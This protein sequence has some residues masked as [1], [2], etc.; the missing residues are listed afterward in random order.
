M[1]RL[2]FKS[3]KPPWKTAEMLLLKNTGGNTKWLKDWMAE[4]PDVQN[5]VTNPTS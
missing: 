2:R 4:N 5:I 3:R 1:D